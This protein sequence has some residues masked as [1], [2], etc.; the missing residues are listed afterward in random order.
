M[1]ILKM[2]FM[3][4]AICLV[5]SGAEASK[6][7]DARDMVTGR[8]LNI[9]GK[10]IEDSGVK[11]K[12]D[13]KDDMIVMKIENNSDKLITID[14]NKAKYIGMDKKA[15]R[16]YD[17]KQKNKGWFET[18]T[19]TSIRVN[20]YYEAYIVPSSNLKSIPSTGISGGNIYIAQKLF[21]ADS[22][23]IKDAKRGYAEII[24]PITEGSPYSGVNRDIVLYVGDKENV[25]IE[26]QPRVQV[27]PFKKIAP[28]ST[29]VNLEKVQ[30]DNTK[31]K[32]EIE[33]REKLLKYLKEQEILKKQLAEKELE[34]Q[35]LL[36]N[37]TP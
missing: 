36:K 15:S 18:L 17:F 22:E 16:A 6:I 4:F 2:G 12:Y 30:E 11:I 21:S 29:S 25:A 20:D 7:Y 9:G 10:T 19:P 24:I 14:W 31:L 1:K 37:T 3:I 34:I 33:S 8:Q 28:T 35:K 26:E 32:T 13:F 27:L 5:T 23:E